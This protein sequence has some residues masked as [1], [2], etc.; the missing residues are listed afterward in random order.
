M[1]KK[2]VAFA[3]LLM[4]GTFFMPLSA[5]FAATD[6][7]N[8]SS[9]TA[10]W[11]G[12]DA[13]RLKA[14]IQAPQGS[15]YQYDYDYTYGD[16]ASLTYALPWSFNFYGQAYS[17]INVDTN[18]NVWFG[19]SGPANSFNLASTGR[20]PVI[21]AWNN[22][23]SSNFYGGVFIQ[24]KTS[25]ERVVIEWQTETYTDEGFNR[26][27]NFE[28]VLYQSG[29]IHIDYKMFSPSGTAD[30][31][32]GISKGDGTNYLS[33]TSN[34]GS[35]PAFQYGRSFSMK[36]I[37]WQ[38]QTKVNNVG[39]TLKV[40]TGTPQSSTNG[41]VFSTYSTTLNVPVAITANIGYAI[42]KVTVNGATQTPIPA[43]PVTYQ[44]GL[45]AYPGNTAQN[46]SVSFISKPLVPVS[47][48]VGPGGQVSP[49]GLLN[50]QYGSNVQ[51]TFTPNTGNSVVSIRGMPN[52][53]TCNGGSCT[54]GPWALNTP[55]VLA[56]TVTSTSLNIT[57][58]F[59]GVIANA[60]RGS[61][62]CP[63]WHR[64]HPDR[65]SHYL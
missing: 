40:G 17:Q 8:L 39:G 63:Y 22:D 37:P 2:G 23:L 54:A 44:M 47:T 35:V 34:Y 32:S 57:G 38:L 59:L 12:T 60:C 29:E 1:K 53:A 18:G 7:F 49:A 64:S 24:H 26:M 27:N 3:L 9:V 62:D 19:S 56:F 20:G 16:E 41:T 33:I 28:T 46:V 11:Y 61:A 21:A 13:S 65:Y 4:L 52:G 58:Y 45:A 50:K 43:S 15:S 10:N 36:V 42:S 48:T 25:P 6:G 5:A 14:P 51:Y 31:G 55:V 30:F